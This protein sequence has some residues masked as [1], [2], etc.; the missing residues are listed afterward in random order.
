MLGK[1]WGK[2]EGKTVE[3]KKKGWEAT[4]LVKKRR[5]NA[6]SFR[7]KQARLFVLLFYIFVLLF[8]FRERRDWF[9]I[10][11]GSEREGKRRNRKANTL[12]ASLSLS[13]IAFL[14]FST[15]PSLFP[16]FSCY[17]SVS[18]S[19]SSG[20]Q[21]AC[22]WSPGNET[23][24]YYLFVMLALLLAVGERKRGGNFQEN[25]TDAGTFQDCF[26]P[27]FAKHIAVYFRYPT[28]CCTNKPQNIFEKV[29]FELRDHRC[30]LPLNQFPLNWRRIKIRKK[31][32]KVS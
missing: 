12:T 2:R 10:K 3:E 13:E 28:Y 18:F 32:I 23:L 8:F 14:F 29:C 21:D 26:F 24:I 9:A 25:V 7:E 5:K 6:V 30:S 4:F 17:F 15:F 31:G 27:T 1:Y 20:K 19:S 16:H 22:N 11:Q